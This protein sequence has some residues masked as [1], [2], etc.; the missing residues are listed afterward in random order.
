MKTRNPYEKPV[1]MAKMIS[2]HG[3]VSPLCAKRP[4]AINLKTDLWTTCKD[5]VTCPKCL[6]TIRSAAPP[7]ATEVEEGSGAGKL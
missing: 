6:A 5:A 4:K 2:A 1:H 3:D 7:V